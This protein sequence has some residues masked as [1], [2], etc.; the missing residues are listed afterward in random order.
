MSKTQKSRTEDFSSQ[1]NDGQQCHAPTAKRPDYMN[2]ADELSKTAKGITWSR[3]PGL[4][5]FE[6]IAE[7]VVAEGFYDMTDLIDTPAHERTQL[8]KR[9]AEGKASQDYSVLRK[10]SD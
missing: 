4:K 8:L 5:E 3:M 7:L 10:I 9:L 2:L 1:R 6:W